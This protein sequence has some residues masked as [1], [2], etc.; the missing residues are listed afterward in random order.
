MNQ[1][2]KR[3]WKVLCWNVRGLNSELRHSSVREKISE[4]QC[5]IA[6]LQETKLTDCS[7]SL[8][9]A[10]CPMGFDQFIESPLRGASGG[11]LTTWRS[12]MF[13]GTLV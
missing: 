6:C 8:V 5:A 1:G 11:L 3:N 10:V 12:D 4:S 9:K 7:R 2:S 13:Q